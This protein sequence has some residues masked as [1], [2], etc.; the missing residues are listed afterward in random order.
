M[1]LMHSGWILLMSICALGILEGEGAERHSVNRNGMILMRLYFTPFET[2]TY[3]PLT[4]ENIE[5]RSTYA[6]W[7][8][9]DTSRRENEHPLVSK[10]RR[11]LQSQPATG[12]ID[13]SFIRLKVVIENDVFYV[14][15]GGFVF[16]PS[17]RK[18][19][20]V[21]KKEMLEIEEE[22]SRLSGVVDVRAGREAGLLK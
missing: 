4:M 18:T 20:T 14:D 2:T 5:D 3:V 7:F 12:G 16:H 22:I 9:R 1:R 15:H 17:S 10:L 6:I 21:S 11:S 8:P 19:F 13:H